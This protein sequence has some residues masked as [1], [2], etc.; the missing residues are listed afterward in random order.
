M[1]ENGYLPWGDLEYGV[2]TGQLP[3]VKTY[4]MDLWHLFKEDPG[5]EDT[6][7]KSMKEHDAALGALT[8]C[9]ALAL[10]SRHLPDLA[11][12]E[13]SQSFIGLIL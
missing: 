8:L 1:I 10:S 11:A 6:F 4:G 13:C 12:A 2:R 7:S 3:F 5:R 9:R